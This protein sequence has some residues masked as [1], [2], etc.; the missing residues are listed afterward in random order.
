MRAVAPALLALA[1]AAPAEAAVKSSAAG[2]FTVESSAVVPA[3][4]A[5]VY[6]MLARVGEWW[7]GAHRYSGDAA[8]LS[9]DPRAGGCFCER[10]PK[11]GGSVEHMRVVLAWP[12]RMLRLS[13]GLGPLQGEG[14]AGS[15]SWTLAPTAAGTEITQTYS[16]GGYVAGGADKLAPIVDQVL[17]EQLDRLKARLAR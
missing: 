11:E 14:V 6:A 9:L 12:G 1:A 8:N 10:L 13:G 4:P 5:E 16:V 17:G 2:G 3:S 15:L 7:N